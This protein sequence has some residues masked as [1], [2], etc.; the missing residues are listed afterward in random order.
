MAKSKLRQVLDDRFGGVIRHGAHSPDSQACALEVAS[1]ARGKPWSDS[2]ASANLPDIRLLN[3]GPWSSD[4]VRTK[5]ILPLMEALWNRWPKWSDAQKR[6]YM[7]RVSTRNIG[8]VLPLALRAVGLEAEAVRC[9]KEHSI[10]AARSAAS[11][12]SAAQLA[13]S[14]AQLAAQSAAW[15]ADD[16]LKLACK[17]WIEE[18]RRKSSA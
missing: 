3:D 14:A 13:A 7:K 11:A 8:E 18:A 17:I 6:D 2:P 5:A 9:E 12:E 10:E 16:V 4:E 1:I 15:S